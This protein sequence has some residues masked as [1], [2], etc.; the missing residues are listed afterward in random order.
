MEHDLT[1]ELRGLSKVF[2]DTTRGKVVHV[3]DNI[4]YSI[5]QGRFVTITGPSGCGKTTLLRIIA[6]LEE[7]TAGLVI[8]KQ[9]DGSDQAGGIGMVFQGYALFPWRT[10][11]QNIQMGLDIMGVPKKEGRGM[12]MKYIRVFGLEGFEHRYPYELSDGM[13]QRVAIAR[14]LIMKPSVVLMDEPFGSLDSHTRNELQEF[15]LNLWKTRGETIIFVTH[16]VGEAVFLSDQILVMSNRPGKIVESFDVDLPRPR[17]RTS[18]EYN[19]L[20]RE[21]LRSLREHM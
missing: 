1:L 14:T 18:P 13:Q 11:L 2:D 9:K 21:V 5:D 12:A 7:A 8:L 6:G 3:L 19:L 4:Q 17:D 16:N 10:T 20:K 15:L